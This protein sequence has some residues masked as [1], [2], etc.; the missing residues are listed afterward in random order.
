MS[1]EAIRT[2]CVG[3]VSTNQP[4]GVPLMMQLMPRAVKSGAKSV[5][6]TSKRS[7]NGFI[8]GPRM[9]T[10]EPKMMKDREYPIKQMN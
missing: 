6:S 1:K 9:E 10:C 7:A 5:S 3:N 2:W 4:E 8:V